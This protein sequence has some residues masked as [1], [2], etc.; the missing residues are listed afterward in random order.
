MTRLYAL[1]VTGL[2]WQ[3][4][5]PNLPIFRQEKVKKLRKV[6]D[7]A[8]SAGAGWLLQYALEQAGIPKEAQVLEKTELGKPYLKNHPHIHF[9]LSHSGSWAVCAVG[10]EPLGVDVEL[11]RCTIEIAKRFFRPDELPETEDSDQLLRLWTAKE[12]FLK[13]IGTGLTVPPNSF[14]VVLGEKKA[15]LEQNFSK[16][17]Y[18]LQEF[19]LNESRICLCA[20]VQAEELEIIKSTP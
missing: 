10:D 12:A 16:L 1:D 6:E 8:R 14:R 9:S 2:D 5:L 4:I 7:K 17:P 18:K 19:S 15:I 3:K 20:T 13:A 11:P